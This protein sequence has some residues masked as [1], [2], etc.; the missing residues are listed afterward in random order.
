MTWYAV[1]VSNAPNNSGPRWELF[2]HD[3]RTARQ[4]RHLSSPNFTETDWL[5]SHYSET[6]NVQLGAPLSKVLFYGPVAGSNRRSHHVVSAS[7]TARP[8]EAV[9]REARTKTIALTKIT[10]DRSDRI[11]VW[12]D[13]P[14]PPGEQVVSVIRKV[15]STAVDEV[16]QTITIRKQSGTHVSTVFSWHVP[17]AA[18]T[19]FSGPLDIRDI[20]R[21]NANLVGRPLVLVADKPFPLFTL[22]NGVGGTIDGLLEFRPTPPHKIDLSAQGS[23]RFS[24]ITNIRQM[25]L[26]YFTSIVPPGHILQA[27]ATEPDGHEGEVHTSISRGTAY[28]N[29][30]CRWDF[31][32][33]LSAREMQSAVEQVNNRMKTPL[34]LHSGQKTRVFS[35]TNEAG[36]VYNGYFELL[37][38][39]TKD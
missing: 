17:N 7:L 32:A 19:F 14:L 5:S 4:L 26:G 28:D 35:V 10:R 31:P 36:G 20:D 30:N 23:V 27:C 2:I 33:N 16:T 25:V 37:R 9:T 15:D 22:T 24:S 34:L 29:E 38:P 18:Q 39:S 13:S 6:E 12:T 3:G 1:G 21:A 8:R 11:S